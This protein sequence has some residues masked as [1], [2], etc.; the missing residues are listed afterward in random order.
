MRSN[1]FNQSK[2]LHD[3]GKSIYLRHERMR[4][5]RL[6]VLHSGGWLQALPTIT[7]LKQKCLL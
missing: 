1:I 6:P 3:T 2:L 7:V 4:V 5:K